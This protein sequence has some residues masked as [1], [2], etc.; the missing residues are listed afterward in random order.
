MMRDLIVSKGSSLIN[1]DFHQRLLI[2]ITQ[3]QKLNPR[4]VPSVSTMGSQ[5][6]NDSISGDIAII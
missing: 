4:F 5:V 1:L 2:I 3:E 6:I